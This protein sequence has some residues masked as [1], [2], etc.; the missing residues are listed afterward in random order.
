MKEDILKALKQ[1]LKYKLPKQTFVGP[2]R[3]GS[4][5]VWFKLG[6]EELHM[7]TISFDQSSIIVGTSKDLSEGER[8]PIDWN[9]C[10]PNNDLE[11]IARTIAV[12]AKNMVPTFKKRVK[13]FKSWGWM[14]LFS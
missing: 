4:I 10:N 1:E 3:N 9:I 14:D 13:G 8:F 2:Y 7:L 11:E 5:S 12:M 6:L